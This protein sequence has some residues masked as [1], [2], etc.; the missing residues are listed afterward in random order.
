MLLF[1]FNSAFIKIGFPGGQEAQD[2]GEKEDETN[3]PPL[4]EIRMPKVA[5]CGPRRSKD[6]HDAD[7]AGKQRESK[8]RAETNSKTG[9]KETK[10][11]M[12]HRRQ[13]AV[14]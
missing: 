12:Q 8:V 3:F 10:K 7:E 1:I 6:G 5:Y 14:I 13:Q 9:S 11:N 4:P 2:V